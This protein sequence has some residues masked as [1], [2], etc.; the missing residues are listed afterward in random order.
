MK[1]QPAPRTPRPARDRGSPARTPFTRETG[2]PRPQSPTVRTRAVLGQPKRT[3]APHV[4]RP[5]GGG[6]P[7]RGVWTS[8]TRSNEF[9][10]GSQRQ[11]PKQAASTWNRRPVTARLGVSSAS[12]TAH[13]A[14]FAPT[15]RMPVNIQ[16]RVKN[17]VAPQS[18]VK[19]QVAAQ[20]HVS[21]PAAS[22]PVLTPRTP[23]QHIGEPK[24]SR[25]A[26]ARVRA[27][28]ATLDDEICSVVSSSVGI[29]SVPPSWSPG[30]V[31]GGSRS[32]RRGVDIGAPARRSPSANARRSPSAR[33]TA[34]LEDEGLGCSLA[35]TSTKSAPPR[36][37]GG[38]DFLPKT[39]KHRPAA[40][41][42]LPQRSTAS[43][44]KE[45]ISKFGYSGQTYGKE[46]TSNCRDRRGPSPASVQRFGFGSSTNS[47]R[48]LEASKMHEQHHGLNARAKAREEAAE[49]AW[50]QERAQRAVEKMM[51]RSPAMTPPHSPEPMPALA[52]CTSLISL[53]EQLS[54]VPPAQGLSPLPMKACLERA[55]SGESEILPSPVQAPR[56]PSLLDLDD[57]SDFQEQDLGSPLPDPDRHVSPADVADLRSPLPDLNQRRAEDETMSPCKSEMLPAPAQA[58][59]NSKRAS[60]TSDDKEGARQSWRGTAYPWPNKKPLGSATKAAPQPV[61]VISSSDSTELASSKV[62]G[63]STPLLTN[64]SDQNTAA[65]YV[66]A[67][68]CKVCNDLRQQSVESAL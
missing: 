24:R 25:S 60:E 26:H 13:T 16:G 44:G 66:A 63:D 43:H 6:W 51:P 18:Q 41:L 22:S 5:G 17:H 8:R 3:N 32:P 62:A 37:L 40:G 38:D 47:Q 36:T 61:G 20:R 9:L 4:H 34:E 14:S 56:R 65:D 29:V 45:N 12:S 7:P 50:Q 31:G 53:V 57:L 33:R 48:G 1:L 58:S 28:T 67:L 49:K 46:N 21:P 27:G 11:P 59:S 15:P 68:L 35:T 52:M 19:N 2:S 42:G 10:P 30:H 54:P 64:D 39:P 55:S 23:K